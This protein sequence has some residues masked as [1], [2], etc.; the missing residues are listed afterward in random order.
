MRSGTTTVNESAAPSGPYVVSSTTDVQD[1]PNASDATTTAATASRYGLQIIYLPAR[2]YGFP[3]CPAISAV[4]T[5]L[6][7]AS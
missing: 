2:P 4:R 3:S 5:M 6:M 7:S 1:L